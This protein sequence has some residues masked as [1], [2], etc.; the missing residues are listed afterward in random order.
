MD[1]ILEVGKIFEKMSHNCHSGLVHKA[2][3]QYW[4][5]SGYSMVGVISNQNEKKAL[6]YMGAALGSFRILAPL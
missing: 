6:Y 1:Q 2:C 4:A 5:P 3:E